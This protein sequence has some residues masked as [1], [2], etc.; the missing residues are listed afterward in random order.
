[1][2]RMD[3]SVLWP[4]V[5]IGG[6][7]PLLAAIDP[8]LHYGHVLTAHGPWSE[9]PL[10]PGL[11]LVPLAVVA[12]YIVGQRPVPAAAQY[13]GA[14]PHLAFFGGV[15]AVFLA[16]QS[17]I[18][19]ISDHL[20]IAHQVEHMLLRTVGPML[21]MLAAPQAALLRG[22]PDWMRRWVVTPL[23]GNR[24]IRMLGIL[25]HPVVATVLFIVTTYFWMIPRYHDLALLDENV[26]YVWHT[27]LLLS[28]LIFFWRIFDPRPSPPGAPL[29]TRLA[30]LVS[31]MLGNILLGSYLSFKSEVLYPAYD[32]VGRLWSIAPITD[33]RFGGLTMWIP[34]SMMFAMAAMSMIFLRGRQEDR[35]IARW[36]GAGRIAADPAQV[37]A[38]QRTANAHLAL[39]LVGVIVA[40]LVVT[41]ATVIAYRYG[42]QALGALPR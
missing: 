19:P 26:H 9:W 22:L 18:E 29:G 42:G 27:T 7:I 23:A 39:G 38:R 6:L 17:P 13:G 34:G 41:F 37:L 11:T 30:M 12:L 16:L 35:I 24:G 33:E 21:I 1:M 31:A 14:W 28:G 36:R 20:F 25:G 10:S 5:A 32:E 2:R 8:V 15:A 3:G 4:A 40:I